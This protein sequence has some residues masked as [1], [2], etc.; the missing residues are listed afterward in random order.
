MEEDDDTPPLDI[1]FVIAASRFGYR[2][3]TD[4]S[5]PC[6]VIWLD[7]EPDR[8]SSGYGKYIEELQQIEQV[9]KY[10]G[11]YQPPTEEEYNRLWERNADE[12]D[13]E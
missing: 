11:F 3:E 4:D 8:D 5:N 2:W 13:E 6:E 1:S 12:N 7:R 9:D 10:R